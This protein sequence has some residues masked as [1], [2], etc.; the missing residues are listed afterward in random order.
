MSTI[1]VG[2]DSS[3]QAREAAR[4]AAQFAVAL[5]VPLHV[6][7]AVQSNQVHEIG[8]G[9][10][11][12]VFNSMDLANE[13]LGSIT[14]EFR[15]TTKVTSAALRTDPATALCEEAERLGASMIVI[16]NKRVQGVSRV[17]G[18]VAGAVAKSAPCDVFVVHTYE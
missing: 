11:A 5:D 12:F 15:R 8:Y 16:G 1:I 4:K 9:S 17:L 3:T 13:V 2:V 7:T 6:V 10:D 18:S 14:D